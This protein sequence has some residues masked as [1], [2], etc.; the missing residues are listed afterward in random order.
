MNTLAERIKH[1]LALRNMN[2][3]QLALKMGLSRSA[4]SLWLSSETKDLSAT[5]ALKL[6]AVLKV[7]PF[8][9]VLGTGPIELSASMNFT[10]DQM[11]LLTTYGSLTEKSQRLAL[12]LLQQIEL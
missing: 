12:R 11:Q 2:Q 6:A 3:S 5:N 4:I 10:Q 7:N 8:W 9:L 1:A